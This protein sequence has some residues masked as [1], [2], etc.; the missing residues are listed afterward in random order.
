VQYILSTETV[1]YQSFSRILQCHAAKYYVQTKPTAVHARKRTDW[2]FCW[3]F[4]TKLDDDQ[5][6]II[7]QSGGCSNRLHFLNF[8]QY[9]CRASKARDYPGPVKYI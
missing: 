4:R 8:E 6:E 1:N 9:Q 3:A 5:A 7:N 2:F